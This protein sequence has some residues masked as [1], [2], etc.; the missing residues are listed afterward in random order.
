MIAIEADSLSKRY[1]IGQLQAAYGT[2]RDSI[3]RSSYVLGR[4]DL[5][6]FGIPGT[7]LRVA[8]SPSGN[9]AGGR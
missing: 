9:R 7:G 2:L 3:A 1:R 8:R 4:R 6:R 5:A